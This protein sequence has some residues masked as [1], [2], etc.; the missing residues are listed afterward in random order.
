MKSFRYYLYVGQAQTKEAFLSKK[1]LIKF[2][3][4]WLG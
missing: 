4:V 3:G 2:Q 1:D